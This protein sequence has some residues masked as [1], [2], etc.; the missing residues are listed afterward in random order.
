MLP[1]IAFSGMGGKSTTPSEVDE[2]IP[3]R[4]ACYRG[5]RASPSVGLKPLRSVR[6]P[7]RWWSPRW[8]SGPPS[9]PM[10]HRQ[11]HILRLDGPSGGSNARNSNKLPP[12]PEEQIPGTG[13]SIGGACV[14]DRRKVAFG[15][16]VVGCP[17]RQS[18]SDWQRKRCT[19]IRGMYRPPHYRPEE[20]LENAR[21][22]RR[23]IS[24]MGG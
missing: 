19:R 24:Q 15:P 11:G 3:A 7:K 13:G 20:R 9:L 22:F 6:I 12:P 4:R 1:S 14:N 2:T 21:K 10:T 5:C 23:R 17:L 18:N 8:P 16:S